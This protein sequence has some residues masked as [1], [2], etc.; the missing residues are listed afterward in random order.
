MQTGTG[1]VNEAIE[2]FLHQL[3]TK[4][5]RAKNTVL[6]YRA[7]LRQFSA[8]LNEVA[9][10]R[11]VLADITGDL[12]AR[13][14][15][16]LGTQGYRPATLSR[17]MAAVRSF[18]ES[19][20]VAGSDSVPELADALRPPPAPRRQPRLL[21]PQEVD[22][23][24][25]A[26]SR[27]GSP[28]SLRDSAL[29]AVLYAT[30]LRAA[31]AVG[32]RLGDLDLPEA[33]LRR[34]SEDGGWISLGQAL[35]ALRRYLDE[36]RPLLVRDSDVTAVFVNQRG[37]PLSRQGL[38]LIVKHWADATG[39]GDKVSPH[40]LRHALIQHMLAGGK[41]RRDIQHVLGLRSPNA[42]RA[43]LKEPVA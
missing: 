5:G 25:A 31:D 28:R 33:R 42:I 23:L 30:G 41:S 4:Q 35:P 16:W 18:L 9:G 29:L 15:A 27:S 13:Y 14:A 10:R 20:A 34:V 2:A 11:V 1:A 24:L 36:A 22:Q 6:A 43:T 8:A 3:Q 7:D 32:L 38:W 12:L 40:S 26:P 19:H 17:K 37:K 39:L 21:T